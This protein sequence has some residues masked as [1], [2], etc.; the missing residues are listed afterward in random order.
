MTGTPIFDGTGAVATAADAEVYELGDAMLQLLLDASQTGGALSAHRCR[1]PD[2]T[3][4]ANPH[5][6]RTATELF[7]VLSGKADLLAGTRLIRAGA[8]DLVVVPP[9]S[10]HA[11]AAAPNCDAELLVV[12]TPGIERFPFFRDLVRVRTGEL[13]METFMATQADYDIYPAD[14]GPWS[15]RSTQTDR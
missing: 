6:H 8:G 4:G 7:Y 11:F 10:A 2:G 14:A 12:I 3:V 13:D 9:T 15:T 5:Q 1:L